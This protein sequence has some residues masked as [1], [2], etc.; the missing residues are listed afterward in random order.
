MLI[1]VAAALVLVVAPLLLGLAGVLR[2][3]RAHEDEPHDAAGWNA[4]LTAASALLYALA[5]NLTFL[6]QEL[7]LVL[8]K[9]L[10]PGVHPTLF[11]N[12]HTWSGEHPLTGLLQG[13]GALAILLSG[14]WCG[15]RLRRR[16]PAGSEWR[17]FLIW[18][19]YQG[20]L[21]A[22]LQVV[23]GSLNPRNDVGMAMAYLG[24][25]PASRAIAACV[26]LCAIPPAALGLARALLALA[27]GAAQLA[28]ARAR[29]MFMFSVATLPGLLGVLLIIPFRL[30]REA[31]EVFAPPLAVT[32]VGML[33][34]QAAAWRLRHVERAALEPPGSL[35]RPL[36]LLIAL[37]LV[38]QL[39]L[40]PGIRL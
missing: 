25:G 6:I 36:E 38:F 14:L 16:P 3:H 23:V 15:W 13:S 17:L 9:A 33:W 5:F 11:H 20:L 31:L 21:Q 39:L 35:L 19:S 8:P 29:S 4:T 24:L 26:A 27:P 28:S 7:F 12:N 1:G 18:M 30:P 22:L 32:V 10:L 2:P 40:R 37:L 34:M